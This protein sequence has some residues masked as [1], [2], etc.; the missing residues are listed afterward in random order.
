MLD[1]LIKCG[2]F[3]TWHE[4][5]NINFH[6]PR[7]SVGFLFIVNWYYRIKLNTSFDQPR[8]VNYCENDQNI[9]IFF[10]QTLLPIS[11]EQKAPKCDFNLLQPKGWPHK[12]D[13]PKTFLQKIFCSTFRD[14]VMSAIKL[15]GG[16]LDCLQ[17]LK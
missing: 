6:K 9:I 3:L 1:A 2:I 4:Y 5:P 17:N 16:I 8:T 14:P 7:Y 11:G 12:F 15:F 13:D 10:L